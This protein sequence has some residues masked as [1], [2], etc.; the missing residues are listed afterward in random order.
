MFHVCW[1]SQRFFILDRFIPFR[2]MWIVLETISAR[3]TAIVRVHPWMCCQ[4]MA[5]YEK[6]RVQST[7][8]TS[9]LLWRCPETYLYY[10]NTLY[11]LSTRWI[12]PQPS[13]PY[14]L[15]CCELQYVSQIRFGTFPVWFCA[16]PVFSSPRFAASL[17]SV[18]HCRVFSF[19][20]RMSCDVTICKLSIN[21][22]NMKTKTVINYEQSLL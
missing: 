10:Q 22:P 3:Y 14:R 18:F 12:E 2:V 16:G 19:L 7:K 6:S 13:Q 15:S 11:V 5:R 1:V 21:L 20:V 17:L 8:F 9:A 4:L